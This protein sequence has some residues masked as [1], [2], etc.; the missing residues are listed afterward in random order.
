MIMFL[1]NALLFL[2]VMQPL[3][4][5]S[6][7]CLIQLSSFLLTGLDDVDYCFV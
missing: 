6:G 7:V 4:I 2:C 1:S 5:G 3:Q